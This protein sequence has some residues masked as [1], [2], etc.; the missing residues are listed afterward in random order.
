VA[1]I[2]ASVLSYNN[3]LNQT[4]ANLTPA[5]TTVTPGWMQTVDSRGVSAIVPQ[6]TID[7]STANIQNNLLPSSGQGKNFTASIQV[8][9]ASSN[10]VN[11]TASGGIQGSGLVAD[12]FIISAGASASYNLLTIDQSVNSIDVSIG[13][14]GVT[15]VTPSPVSYAI[16]S[17]TGWWNP[18]PIQ[19]AVAYNPNVSGYKFNQAQPY[20]FAKQGNFGFLSRLMIAQQPTL[21][22]TFYTSNYQSVQQKIQEQSHWGVSFLGIPLAGGSQSYYSASTTVNQSA[23]TV[24]VTMTPV[25]INTPVTPTDQLAYVIGAEVLWPGAAS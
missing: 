21:T 17:G 23:N 15:T 6:I 14:N 8:S 12:L 4:R 13:F 1:N 10:T 24:T 22:L 19:A 16:S 18:A 2:Q 25:G 9:R 11:I 3:Q 5:P 20:N 7:E